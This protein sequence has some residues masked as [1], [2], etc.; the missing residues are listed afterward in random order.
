MLVLTMVPSLYIPDCKHDPQGTYARPYQ[1]DG[2]P[3]HIYE[4]LLPALVFLSQRVTDIEANKPKATGQLGKARYRTVQNY[5][6]SDQN[7]K[8]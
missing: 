1:H 6:S 5:N 8:L 4:H 2:R 3:Q 7:S